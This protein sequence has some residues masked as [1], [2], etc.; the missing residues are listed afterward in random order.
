[1]AMQ[2]D[3]NFQKAKRHDADR[4]RS[5]Q[6][7]ALAR[8][9]LLLLVTVPVATYVSILA[10][11]TNHPVTAANVFI[12]V[13]LLSGAVGGLRAGLLS[14][15]VVS[16]IYNFFVRFPVYA[17]GFE[18][19]DDVVPVL[20]LTLTALASG[21]VS[22]QLRSQVRSTKQASESLGRLLDFSRRLHR[23]RSLDSI[24]AELVQAIDDPDALVA[25]LADIA[26][27]Y[28]FRDIE[29]WEAA[30]AR[31]I[32]QRGE[33][34]SAPQPI[35]DR[36]GIVSLVIMAIERRE[37]LVEDAQ[38]EAAIRSEAL[39]TALIS[40][41]AHDLRTPLAAI[42]ATATNLQDLGPTLGEDERHRMLA[43]IREQCARLVDFST[44]MLHLG[45]LQGGAIDEEFDIVDLQEAVGSAVAAVR[46]MAGSRAIEVDMADEA[47][48]ARANPLLL[49]QA[50][51]NLLENALR[52]SPTGSPVTVSLGMKAGQ[53]VITI[54]DSGPG[55]P[56]QDLPHVFERFYR[57]AN[58]TGQPGHGLGLAVVEAFTA[59]IGG[60]VELRSRTEAPTGTEAIVRLNAFEL[61]LRELE[62]EHG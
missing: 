49:E 26:A 48:F 37:L 43:T 29:R 7:R 58:G 61:D 59:A 31:Q 6:W 14:A 36:E 56:A 47:L 9:A 38:A 21:W 44:K 12:V 10:R 15:A 28:T 33:V 34:R 42:G 4:I 3:E 24:A 41:L 19:I 18:A 8:D 22:G 25:C 17:L 20:A 53:V 60:E 39:K 52:Y 40:S 45:R 5:A 54:A 55:I 35:L 16:L 1:M 30:V 57:G 23:A 46:T 27:A 51:V 13:V 62:E 2:G 11:E 50:L 32:L